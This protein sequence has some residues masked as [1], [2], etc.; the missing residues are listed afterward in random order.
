MKCAAQSR[1]MCAIAQ[2]SRCAAQLRDCAYRSSAPNNNK[3]KFKFFYCTT[4]VWYSGMA[5]CYNKVLY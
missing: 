3:F 5:K 1:K 2:L 4:K